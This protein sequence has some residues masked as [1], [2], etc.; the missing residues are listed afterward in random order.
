[1]AGTIALCTPALSTNAK[2]HLVIIGGGA[3]GAAMVRAIRAQ[4]PD[5]FQITLIAKNNIYHAPYALHDFQHPNSCQNHPIDLKR[6]FAPMG[7]NVIIAPV[8][9]ISPE[10]KTIQL[11]GAGATNLSYDILVAAPGISLKWAKLGLHNMSDATALWTS[12]AMPCDVHKMLQNT[13]DNGTFALVAP[14]GHYRC[15]PAVY[16]RACFAAHW[17]K[18]HN[19]NAKILII[20][21]KDQYPMQALFEEAYA[22]YYDDM[23]EWVPREFH[24]GITRIDIGAGEIHTD[25][26]LF[27][28]DVL[29]I[30]PPQQAPD[31]LIESELTDK[32]NYGAILTPTMQSA[33]SKDIYIIGDAAAAGEISKSAMSARV[34]AQLAASDIIARHTNVASSERVALADNCWTVVA[35]DDA[36]TLGG[37]YTANGTKFISRERFMSVVDDTADLRESQAAT[38]AKWP[39]EMQEFLYGAP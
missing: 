26:E 24:G 1:M 11:G 27:K 31:F 5:K 8:D 36:I 34:E 22:D 29:N 32:H 35:P 20:D 3:A 13:P 19:K 10:A 6:V 23:I 39:K 18:A 28:A 25:S 30:I 38:A 17:F 15:P 14:A 4:A 16:E 7:V 33:R 21:E 9:K 12:Q 37:T 2:P